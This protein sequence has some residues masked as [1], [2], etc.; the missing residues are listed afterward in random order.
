MGLNLVE[1]RLEESESFMQTNVFEE[2]DLAGFGGLGVGSK[3]SHC[4]ER[5]WG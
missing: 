1:I 2:I 5:G 4:E 3:L